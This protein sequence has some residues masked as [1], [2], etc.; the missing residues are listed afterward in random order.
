MSI[1][2]DTV[3]RISHPLIYFFGYVNLVVINYFIMQVNLQLLA[4]CYLS[5]SQAY[6]AYYILKGTLHSS[7]LVLYVNI[8]YIVLFVFGKTKLVLHCE[9]KVQKRLSLGIYLHSHALSWI[10]LERL[11]LHCCPVKIMLKKYMALLFY[12]FYKNSPYPWAL[13]TSFAS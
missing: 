4:R 5:N 1:Q 8:S 2:I 7:V 10:F 3:T 6:S 9:M 12:F 13:Y 11:K